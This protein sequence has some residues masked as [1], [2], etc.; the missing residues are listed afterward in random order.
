MR[1]VIFER[2]GGPDV[3][4]E[5]ELDRP[6]PG[7]RQVLV[8]VKAS[9]VNPVDIQTRRGDY[10]ELTPAPGRLGVDVSG[11]VE[12]VGNSVSEFRPGDE[13]FYAPRLLQNEGGYA[14]YH[15][16]DADIVAL[17]PATLSFEEAAALPLAAGTAWE[18]LIE[19]GQI[20]PG[21]QL[22]I[23]GASGGVGVYAVQIAH[24]AGAFVV[25][26][27]RAENADFVKG[28]G[29]DVVVDYRA[30]R[31]SELLR[32]ATKGRGFSAILD[33]VGAGTI[34]N[35]LSLLAPFGRIISIVDHSR[36]QNLVHGWEK[37]ATLH[38]VLTTQ[39]RERLQRLADMAER[40]LLRPVIEKILPLAEA[41][42]AH[43]LVEAGAR[44][45]KIVLRV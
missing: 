5:V 45:G 36:P 20:E 21:E 3:L 41:R 6:I 31:L 33:T 34:E 11:I 2:F 37:N 19:R 44:C 1:A 25:A 28:L 12:A 23:H 10:A 17:K 42:E 27:C 40:G 13:V 30:D 29:A 24:A 4:R 38:F 22:L 9:S 35:S 8:R 39:K 15:T 43:E 26:T 18:C 14:E 16:E 7:P 32:E